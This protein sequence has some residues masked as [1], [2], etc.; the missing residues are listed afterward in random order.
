MGEI[1]ERGVFVC[2]CVSILGHARDN[3]AHILIATNF[4]KNL[5]H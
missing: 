3:N 2:S 1:G 4:Y 5:R